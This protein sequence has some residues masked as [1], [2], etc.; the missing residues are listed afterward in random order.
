M[1]IGM[2]ESASW[3]ITYLSCLIRLHHYYYGTSARI[4][5]VWS[6]DCLWLQKDHLHLVSWMVKLIGMPAQTTCA[7]LDS[8]QWSETNFPGPRVGQHRVRH[9]RCP[10]PAVRHQLVKWCVVSLPEWLMQ[11]ATQEHTVYP[12]SGRGAVR[13]ARECARALY[14]LAPVVSVIWGTSEA[15]EGERL[16]SLC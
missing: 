14:Y 2:L 1:A 11:E 4:I 8:V 12:G 6:A 15:R 16:P 7:D 3:L 5:S 10:D 13:P 9:C